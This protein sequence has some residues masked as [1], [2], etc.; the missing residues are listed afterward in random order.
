MKKEIKPHL[1]EIAKIMELT[2]ID[3]DTYKGKHG[4]LFKATNFG[5]IPQAYYNK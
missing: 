2:K 3:G 1:E 4:Q 5:F